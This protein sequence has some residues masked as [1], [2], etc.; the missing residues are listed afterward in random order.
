MMNKKGAELSM[1]VIIVAILVILVLVILAYFFLGGTAKLFGGIQQ[2]AP[3]N[4]DIA[5][6]DCASKCELAQTYTIDS[7]KTNSGY[8]TKWIKYDKDGDGVYDQ[9]RR[10]YADDIDIDCPGVKEKCEGEDTEDLNI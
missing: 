1:N 3:D 2:Y 7:Q 10:C 5:K 8:C 6:Q 9:R 4:I